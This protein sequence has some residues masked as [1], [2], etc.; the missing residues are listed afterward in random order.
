[1]RTGISLFFKEINN[2]LPAQYLS[3]STEQFLFKETQ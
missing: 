1:M 2:S 3:D